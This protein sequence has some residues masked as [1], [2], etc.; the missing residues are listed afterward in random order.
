VRLGE[1]EV[2]RN[3]VWKLQK[4]HDGVG[5][6]DVDMKPGY[7][8]FGKRIWKVYLACC[9]SQISTTIFENSYHLHDHHYYYCFITRAHSFPQAVEFALWH[10]ILTVTRN[11]RNDR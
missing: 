1:G 6:D 9:T 8:F 7:N 5:G 10:R 2:Y 3:V 11:M 4:C